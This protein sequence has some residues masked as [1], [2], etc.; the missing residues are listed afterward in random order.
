MQSSAYAAQGQGGSAP[1][2]YAH[3]FHPPQVF[4]NVYARARHASLLHQGRAA[5]QTTRRPRALLSVDFPN[6]G[7]GSLSEFFQKT[8][9]WSYQPLKTLFTVVFIAWMGLLYIPILALLNLS[10]I[11][12]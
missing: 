11:H 10:L 12:I 9:I 2:T 8:P 4:E 7:H 5:F 1:G 3:W 6:Q